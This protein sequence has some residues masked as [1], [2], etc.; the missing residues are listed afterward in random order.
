MSKI[1]VDQIG[2]NGIETPTQGLF[3]VLTQSNIEIIWRLKQVS[4]RKNDEFE[5]L[6]KEVS[7]LKSDMSDIKSLL[8]TLVQSK[9]RKHYDD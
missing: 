9:Q 3:N 8:L 6:Q 4:K 2:I 1:A 7:E 5:T